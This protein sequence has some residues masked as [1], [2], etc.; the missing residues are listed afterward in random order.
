MLEVNEVKIE[1]VLNPTS[2]DL[3]EYVIN[4]YFGCEFACLYCYARSNR[5]AQRK[6]KPWGRY[7]DIRINAPELLEKEIAVKKPKTVLLGSTTECFQAVEK[8]YCISGKILEILNRNK[9]NY[10]ILARSPMIIKYLP[11]LEEGYCSKI[12]FTVNNLN[13]EAKSLLEPNSPDFDERIDTI[14]VLLNHKLPIIPYFCPVFPWI[15][16]LKD[17]FLNFI[18]SEFIE[19]ECLNFRLHNIEEIIKTIAMLDLSINEKYENM[20]HNKSF[21]DQVWQSII[22]DIETQAFAAKKKFKVHC[23]GFGDYFKNTYADNTHLLTN[24]TKI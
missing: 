10:V 21:Y 18:D 22:T 5:L 24:D 1:R 7:V 20:Q 17:V 4:P 23:H 8:K 11:L 14:N 2:I 15:S 13:H 16:N 19:F 12:Y 3:G 6:N 9:I